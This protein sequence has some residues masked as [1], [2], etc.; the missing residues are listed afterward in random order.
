LLRFA[1][2][3]PKNRRSGDFLPYKLPKPPMYRGFCDKFT[4]DEQVAQKP[5]SATGC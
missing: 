5:T 1:H 4:A 3:T 2:K